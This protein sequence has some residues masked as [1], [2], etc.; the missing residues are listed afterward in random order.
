[1]CN[2]YH[3]KDGS[4]FVRLCKL[5]GHQGER[6]EVTPDRLNEWNGYYRD[7]VVG[8]LSLFYKV[9]AARKAKVSRIVLMR[10]YLNNA[11]QDTVEDMA[12]YMDAQYEIDSQHKIVAFYAKRGISQGSIARCESFGMQRVRNS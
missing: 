4:S 7:N 10:F 9:K 1:M 3:R 11:T 6:I 12:R 8:C 5:T 2:T